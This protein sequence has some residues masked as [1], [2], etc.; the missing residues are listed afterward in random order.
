[1]RDIDFFSSNSY[2]YLPIKQNPKVALVVDDVK[3]SLNAFKLY[4]P[5]SSKAQKFKSVVKFAFSTLNFIFKPLVSSKKKKSKF[6]SYLESELGEELIVSLYFATLKDKIVL[7][8][9]SKDAKILGY[10]K[11]PLNDVGLKHIENEIKAFEILSS[12]G[13]VDKPV[14]TKKYEGTPFLLL[15]ELDGVIDKVKESSL[16]VILAKFK[17]E[18]SFTLACH[19][20]VL[21]LKSAL[22]RNDMS[23]YLVTVE[24]ICSKSTLEYKL[25][26]EHG[27]FTP[28]NIVKVG[29][30][31]IPFDF[32]YFVED[33][34]E[35]FD[36]IKYYYQ[37]GKLLESKK[38]EA[39]VAF[40]EK[41]VAIP[42]IEK[43]LML[44]LIKEVLRGIE[45]N[46]D[47]AFEKEMIK[48]LENI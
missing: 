10:L 48:T 14:L 43:L 36:H 16:E 22:E 38:G 31:Y 40:I 41:K 39:L 47:C 9:Q 27:D 3:F 42:E 44:F 15:K 23:E 5:F 45:E 6:V 1:M 35:H 19:P 26:Y 34:L 28:W 13:I 30:E 18:N 20:R 11:Y 29:E 37:I 33:G 7:Q 17:R 25:V 21:E 24:S 32:E 12:K 8:L 46:E 2:I 4:N